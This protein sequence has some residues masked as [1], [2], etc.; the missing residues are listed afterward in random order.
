MRRKHYIIMSMESCINM[1]VTRWNQTQDDS[2]VNCATDMRD[3]HD[4]MNAV[5]QH[6]SLNN[7]DMKLLFNDM[8][9]YVD[10]VLIANN[11]Q[12]IDIVDYLIPMRHG[13]H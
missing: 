10:D 3:V 7:K 4:R 6:Y 11:Q 8:P 13:L 9:A 5:K 1:A 12:V 2:P